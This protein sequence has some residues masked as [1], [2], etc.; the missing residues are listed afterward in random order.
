[1]VLWSFAVIGILAAAVLVLAL[2]QLSL[3]RCLREITQTLQDTTASDTNALITVSSG[4]RAVRALAAKLNVQLRLLRQERLRLQNGDADLKAALTNAAHDLRTPLTAICG[5]LDLLD[6]TPL[7]PQTRE[8]LCVIR[9]R[10]EALRALSEELLRYCVVASTADALRP[11]PLRLND[12]LEQSLAAFY[13]VLSGRGITP[14]IH[15]PEAAVVRTL[16]AAALRRIL[17]NILANAAKYSVGDL[18][19]CLTADGTVSFENTAPQLDAVQTQR[20]FDR[21]Y[22]LETGAGS[23]GLG[24]SIAKLL[25]ERMGGSIGADYA[26]GRLRIWVQFSA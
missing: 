25:T 4:D 12:A 10:A 5:Y 21:F 18:R 8:Y 26:D 16:D 19:V 23:T 9:E 17:G 22:T 20:L 13:G 7:S 1:M 15:I 6:S 11:T 2:K 24:L 14:E 3:R